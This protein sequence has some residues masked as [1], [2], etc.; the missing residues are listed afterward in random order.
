MHKCNDHFLK[1][2]SDLQMT[3]P[4]LIIYPKSEHTNKSTYLL[5]IQ[6]KKTKVTKKKKAALNK[7][8]QLTIITLLNLKNQYVIRLQCLPLVNPHL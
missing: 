1:K 3:N 2:V 7:S 5:Q 6:N 8:I 4:L